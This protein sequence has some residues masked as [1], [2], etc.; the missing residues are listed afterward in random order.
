MEGTS[1]RLDQQERE[2]VRERLYQTID[3]YDRS[4]LTLSGGALTASVLFADRLVEGQAEWLWVLG[5]S[6]VALILSLLVLLITHPLT[7]RS[8]E[9]KLEGKSP[10]KN[11]GPGSWAFWLSMTAGVLFVVGVSGLA[12]FAIINFT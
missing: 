1:Q 12:T 10:K 3:S 8:L 11:A 9:R 6:W 7:A 5:T 4:V 2:K